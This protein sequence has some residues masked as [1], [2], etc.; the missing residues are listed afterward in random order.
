[1]NKLL[2]LFSLVLI[3]RSTTFG[4]TPADLHGTWQL[5]YTTTLASLHD[6]SQARYQL[7]ADDT[8][9]HLQAGMEGLSVTFS[10]NKNY[11]LTSSQGDEVTGS[12]QWKQ[13][14]SSLTVTTN[15]L[16]KTYLVQGLSES[17][18]VLTV[19][20]PTNDRVIFHTWYL[21]KQ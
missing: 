8:K 18:L 14:G 2:L 10:P 1:M 19:E 21:E 4:Q 7:L 11:Q 5:N 12:W 16:E 13:N 6:E 3:V 17:H 15:Q 20:D 9:V